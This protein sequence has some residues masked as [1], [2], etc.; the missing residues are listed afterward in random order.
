MMNCKGIL[1]IVKHTNLFVFVTKNILYCVKCL[2]TKVGKCN[3][4]KQKKISQKLT[5]RS[6]CKVKLGN[7]LIHSD[8]KI[9]SKSFKSKSPRIPKVFLSA[10]D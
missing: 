1:P 6:Q 3:E 8:F 7:F 5:L 2:I 10:Y 9:V 4:T